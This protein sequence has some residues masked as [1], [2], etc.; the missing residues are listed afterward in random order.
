M[1]VEAQSVLVT[2]QQHDELEGCLYFACPS[3]ASSSVPRDVN[4]Y[5]KIK[6]DDYESIVKQI[7]EQD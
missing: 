1:E 3:G 5:A 7:R 2:G 4:G 6:T